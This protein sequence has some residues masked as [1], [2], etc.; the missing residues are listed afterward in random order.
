M[1]DVQQLTKSYSGIPAIEGISFSIA[2][3]EVLGYL[4]PNGAG[5]STTVKILAGLIE[6]GGG[7]IYLDGIDIR[8]DMEA[9]KRRIGYVPEQCEIYPHLTAFEYMQLVGRLHDLPERRLADTACSLLTQF[10]L[11][12]DMHTPISCFSKGMR[13]K[14]LL[15]AA[16]IH[17][18]DILLWD[19]PLSGLDVTGALMVRDLIRHLSRSG[20]IILYS[21]HVLEVVEKICSRVIILNQG[22]IAAQGEVSE[23]RRLME[24][25][26]LETIFRELVVRTDT[27]AIAAQIAT[28][29]GAA[30]G[31][32]G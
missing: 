21:S 5:K 22:R 4:G 30:A 13:Q 24:L 14:V 16:L 18:P 29:I 17:N 32:N 11:R 20:K 25:P 31:T 2:P 1:I 28:T 7:H 15:A 23:L 27:E 19:E 12:L 10:D 8:R 3:G 26:D 6:A 9:Y